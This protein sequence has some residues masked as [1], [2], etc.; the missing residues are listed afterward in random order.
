LIIPCDSTQPTL[1]V[2]V[3]ANDLAVGAA[4][5]ALRT[6][7]GFSGGQANTNSVQYFVEAFLNETPSTPGGVTT[8]E[9]L[10]DVTITGQA[11]D[12][13]G[14]FTLTGSDLRCHPIT[15]QFPP[16]LT[17][18][19]KNSTKRFTIELNVT[20]KNFAGDATRPPVLFNTVLTNN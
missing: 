12:A 1:K 8:T 11:A 14:F 20:L 16:A 13:T 3:T 19:I 7:L 6:M 18:R 15:V 17:N 9:Q 10:T 4:P 5:V 2:A